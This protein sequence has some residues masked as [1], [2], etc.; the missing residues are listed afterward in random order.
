MDDTL[1]RGSIGF[2]MGCGSISIP[3]DAGSLVAPA[4]RTV[5]E[6]YVKVVVPLPH[7]PTLD[8]M[9]AQELKGLVSVKTEDLTGLM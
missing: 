2:A 1:L 8:D 6:D 9:R 3:M 5:L 7:E 4:A